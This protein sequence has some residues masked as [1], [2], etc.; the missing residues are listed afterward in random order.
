MDKNERKR[1]KAQFKKSE[2]D[3]VLQSAE[4]QKPP[5]GFGM[6]L[7][8]NQ[9]QT[10]RNMAAVLAEVVDNKGQEICLA[11]SLPFDC[12]EFDFQWEDSE[13]YD[14]YFEQCAAAISAETG[15]P[16]YQGDRGPRGTA[17]FEAWLA[18]VCPD[19]DHTDRLTVWHRNSLFIYLRTSWVDKEAPILIA[20]GS[21][22]AKS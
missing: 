8:H 17:E 10:D 1:L 7:R 3:L 18:R 2:L 16:V 12:A 6:S 13:G 15:P 22:E 14:A 20:A 11:L 4:S 5:Y 9:Y 19:S 21:K